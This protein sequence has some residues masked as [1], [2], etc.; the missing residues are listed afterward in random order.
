VDLLTVSDYR[1]RTN[2]L[3][4]FIGSDKINHNQDTSVDRH[5]FALR[6]TCDE[7][8]IT[9]LGLCELQPLI[10]TA[11]ALAGLGPKGELRKDILQIQSRFS[12]G[13]TFDSPRSS[14]SSTEKTGFDG[15]AI[16]QCPFCKESFPFGTLDFHQGLCSK[17]VQGPTP[18]ESPPISHA[19]KASA[20]S[21]NFDAEAVARDGVDDETP[22]PI[23]SQTKSQAPP[24]A[25]TPGGRIF[26]RVPTFLTQPH[27]TNSRTHPWQNPSLPEIEPLVANEGGISDAIAKRLWDHAI[28]HPLQDD[29]EFWPPKLLDHLFNESAVRQVVEELV[30]LRK[31][32]VNDAKIQRSTEDATTYWADI[33]CGNS[34]SFR[35]LLAL[36]ILVEK[37]ECIQHFVSQDVT[38]KKMPLGRESYVC[39]KLSRKDAVLCLGLQKKLKVPFLAPEERVGGVSEVIFEV[40]DIEPW[41]RTSKE[42]QRSL[43]LQSGGSVSGATAQQPEMTLG[44]GYGDVYQ[45]FIHPWQHSFHET[46]RSVRSLN[47]QMNRRLG[48]V[49]LTSLCSSYLLTRICLL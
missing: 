26:S 24:A 45:I 40:G 10:Q 27:G 17:Q 20:L 5:I 31:L 14:I 25:R 1:I 44:G 43:S 28:D 23:P 13:A 22:L 35:H 21:D 41:Y 29:Q 33:V 3:T 2:K 37:P 39:A 49:K 16:E 18:L 7:L 6:K 47:F 12:E 38:D 46:L 9:Q 19:Q 34:T 36:L 11:Q 30:N 15:E 32:P 42:P 4:K 48:E 8:T